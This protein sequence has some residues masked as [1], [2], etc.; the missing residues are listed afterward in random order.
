M[1]NLAR[2]NERVWVRWR[3]T[4]V[5]TDLIQLSCDSH[6]L[7]YTQWKCESLHCVNISYCASSSILSSSWPYFCASTN[8]FL[9]PIL[10]VLIVIDRALRRHILLGIGTPLSNHL[11]GFTTV[12]LDGRND[13]FHRV[14]DYDVELSSEF[15]RSLVRQLD[16]VVQ[17][18]RPN[19]EQARVADRG[20][21]NRAVRG[22]QFLQLV[23]L[24]DRYFRFRWWPL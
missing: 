5:Q 3:G 8:L 6:L 10:R 21:I 15:I 18:V 14:L 4:M 20:Q 7:N 24:I 13:H 2:K 16:A 9:R 17:L 11:R 1:Q 23:Q 22:A 12:A 19:L